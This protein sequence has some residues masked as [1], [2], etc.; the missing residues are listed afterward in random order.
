MFKIHSLLLLTVLFF[1]TNQFAQEY[2]ENNT[3]NDSSVGQDIQ[4]FTTRANKYNQQNTTG[5]PYLNEEFENGSLLSENNVV[6]SSVFLRYNVVHDEFQLKQLANQSDEQVQAVR[7]SPDI[8]VKISDDIY[9]Y[10]IPGNGVGGYYNILFEGNKLNLYKKSSKKFVEGQKSVNMMTGNVP[11]RL[12][13][14]SNYFIVNSKGEFTEL[15]NSKNKK[16]ETIAGD[17]K[18]ELK[19][20]AKSKGLNIN[21]EEDLIELIAYFNKNF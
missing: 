3:Q 1:T 20:I 21:K 9:T 16:F 19:K 12:V 5:T 10:V 15:P 13:D 18:N 6:F 17:Q 2:S 7:K 4:N 11:N 8:Y 14:E